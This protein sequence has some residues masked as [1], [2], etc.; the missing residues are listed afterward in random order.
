LVVGWLSS[1]ANHHRREIEWGKDQ[2]DRLYAL[3]RE[4]LSSKGERLDLDGMADAIVRIFN[5]EYCGIHVPIGKNGWKSVSLSSAYPRGLTPPEHD[6][7]KADLLTEILREQ[8]RQ[9]EYRILKSAKGLVGV[10]AVRGG[11]LSE[12]TV[13]A[14]SG[15]VGLSLQRWIPHRRSRL[16]AAK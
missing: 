3:S 5:L 10:M 13:S 16:K 9:V 15:L 7:S 6:H 2:V 14:L 12:E 11:H 4:L 8:N 1:L